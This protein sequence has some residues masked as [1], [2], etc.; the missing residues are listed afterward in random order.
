MC[1]S[2]FPIHVYVIVTSSPKPQNIQFTTT[3]WIE[4]QQMLTLERLEPF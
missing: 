4:T 1:P 2:E 3:Q